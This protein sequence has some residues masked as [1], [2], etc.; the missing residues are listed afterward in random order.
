MHTEKTGQDGDCV[1][2][3]EFEEVGGQINIPPGGPRQ[4]WKVI[5]WAV[6]CPTCGAS[7]TKSLSGK[8]INSEGLSEHYRVCTECELRF[9]VVSE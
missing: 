2:L 9:R 3:D 7:S 8:R 6:R 4:L 5:A 1:T